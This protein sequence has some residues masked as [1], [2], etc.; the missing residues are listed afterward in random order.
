MV[1][2]LF[3]IVVSSVV[4]ALVALFSLFNG[5]FKFNYK[6]NYSAPE[7]YSV[8]N[9]TYC[10]NDIN[11]VKINWTSGDI[12]MIE[13]DGKN[14]TVSEEIKKS[15]NKV[16]DDM[17]LH[18]KIL[19]K[20]LI[21]YPA[22]SG[23]RLSDIKKDLVVK[24]P[25]NLMNVSLDVN[26]FNLKYEKITAKNFNIE[27]NAGSAEISFLDVNKAKFECNATSVKL[28]LLSNLGSKININGNVSSAVI[29][30]NKKFTGNEE[31]EYIGDGKCLLDIS[32]VSSKV[33]IKS[34]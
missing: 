17:R 8:G 32:T 24:I 12:L 29:I 7:S 27:A 19:D 21:V 22:K 4:A 26:A 13:T 20:K 11:S 31:V 2:G 3:V 18:W 30:N 15:K 16:T 5:F 28:D 34:I 10:A 14:L 1:K 23:C 9:A 6:D 25:K 33:E